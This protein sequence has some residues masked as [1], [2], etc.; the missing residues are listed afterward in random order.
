MMFSSQYYLQVYIVKHR[1]EVT[2]FEKQNAHQKLLL[3]L[4]LMMTIHKIQL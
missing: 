4:V 1:Y 2:D 3:C